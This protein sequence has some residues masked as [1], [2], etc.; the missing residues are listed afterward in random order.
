MT[1]FKQTTT[2]KNDFLFPSGNVCR[3]IDCSCVSRSVF[4]AID[5]QTVV[6]IIKLTKAG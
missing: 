1:R 3:C 6:G 2:I 5:P 4:D